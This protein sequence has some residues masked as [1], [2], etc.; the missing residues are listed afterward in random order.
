MANHH[1]AIHQLFFLYCIQPLEDRSGRLSSAS[2]NHVFAYQL[3]NASLHISGFYSMFLT[4]GSSLRTSNMNQSF[5]Y[6]YLYLVYKMISRRSQCYSFPEA[7]HDRILRVGTS[8]NR[9]QFELVAFS[10]ISK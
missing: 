10:V 6:Q 1:M 5:Q 8:I 4:I 2:L 3:R 7:I 9:P